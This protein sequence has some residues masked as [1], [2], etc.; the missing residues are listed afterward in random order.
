MSLSAFDSGEHRDSFSSEVLLRCPRCNSLAVSRTF[1]PETQDWFAPRRVTCTSCSYSKLWQGRA[2]GR[3]RGQD[4][5]DD[6]FHLPLYLQ[7]QCTQG[8]LWAYNQDHLRYMQAWL[9]SPLRARRKDPQF[10]WANGSFLS[11]LPRW[12]KSAKSRA[13]V[14]AALRKLSSIAEAATPNPSLLPNR[15]GALRRLPRSGELKR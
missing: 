1:D 12:I 13:S 6:Y 2:V 14:A 5:M 3:A 8:P 7:V 9:E 4:A 11:R 15:Y 10:G